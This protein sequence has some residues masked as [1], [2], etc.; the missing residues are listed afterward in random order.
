[1]DFELNGTPL[2]YYFINNQWVILANRR[3]IYGAFVISKNLHHE[4]N[5]GIGYNPNS[6]RK[7]R[8]VYVCFWHT[9][10]GV[11]VANISPPP[12]PPSGPISI[13]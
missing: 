9:S 2:L 13:I 12:F 6:S 1:M 11:P 8:V 5:R 4:N 10:S 7:Y 3:N